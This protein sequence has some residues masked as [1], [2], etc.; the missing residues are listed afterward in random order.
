MTA[1][2]IRKTDTLA[3]QPADYIVQDNTINNETMISLIGQGTENYGGPLQQ[4]VIDLLTNFYTHNA[5]DY[6]RAVPGQLIYCGGDDLRLYT[7]ST[8]YKSLVL[9]EIA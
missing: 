9:A 8:T 6:D 5:D 1:Y 2:S 4:N 7:S 3:N